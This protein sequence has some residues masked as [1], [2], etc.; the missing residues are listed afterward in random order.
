MR[1]WIFLITLFYFINCQAQSTNSYVVVLGIAQD[2][3]YPHLGCDKSCCDQAWKNPDLKK[4]VSSIAIVDPQSLKWWLVEATP[5]IKDQLMLFQNLTGGQFPYLPEGIF[6][7]HA[8][9][10]HYTGLVQLGKEVMNTRGVKVYVLPRMKKFLETNGPWSQ[11]VELNNIVLNELKPNEQVNISP[12][13]SITAMTVPHR[14]EFSETAAFIISTSLSN[15]LF[16]PDIDKWEKWNV[17]LHD[18]LNNIDIAFIDGTFY[19]GNELPNRNINEIPHPLMIETMTRF[20]KESDQ[21]KA[22]IHFIHFN[23][24]NPVLHNSAILNEILVKG[25]H[26]AVQGASY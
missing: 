6:I 26:L 20:E 1:I 24:S 19:S 12:V 7:T 5:D 17:S 4:F 16:L 22:K 23:H 3:G 2:G 15:Y 14:D 18:L 10:G 11:L 25:Y 9:I 21:V 13:I 8:H